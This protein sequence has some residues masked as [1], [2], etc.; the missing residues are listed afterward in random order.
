MLSVIGAIPM[1]ML[2]D[3]AAPG[4]QPDIH[5]VRATAR[6]GLLAAQQGCRAAAGQV[7]R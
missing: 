3:A 5:G 7:S 2:G 4:R 1:A 6:R